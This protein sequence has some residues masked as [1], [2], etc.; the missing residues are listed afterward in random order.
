MTGTTLDYAG[1]ELALF[2]HAVNWKSYWARGL[3]PYVGG[4]V[5]DVGAGI[6]S[7]VAPLVSARVSQWTCL[8]PD[9]AL[10]ATMQARKEQGELP[11]HCT[12]RQGVLGDLPALEQFNSIVYIDVLEHIADDRAEVALAAAHLAP[13]GRLVVLCPAHQF[14]FSPFDTAIGHHRRYSRAAMIGLAPPGC[15][16]E[17][18]RLLDSVGFFAS[19]ANKL[20]LRSAHPS[21]GQI[22]LWDRLMVPA[23]RVIDPLLGYRF[24]KTVIAVWSRA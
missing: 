8:E 7:N 14:L 9:G 3:A 10:V 15:R 1:S 22:G 23:S 6:G 20:L 19:L 4:R 16:L 5:L 11:D 17:F 18:C 12:V 2:A 24:G 13:G 21:A